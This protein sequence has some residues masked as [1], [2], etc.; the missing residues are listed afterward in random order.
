MQIATHFFN[1][2]G[3]INFCHDIELAPPS[4]YHENLTMKALDIHKRTVQAV[5]YFPYFPLVPTQ[6]PSGGSHGIWRLSIGEWL[7][8]Y[9]ADQ[10]GWGKRAMLSNIYSTQNVSGFDRRFSYIKRYT[11]YVALHAEHIRFS[12]TN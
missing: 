9:S 4:I 7:A 5:Y 3:D 8:E 6:M 12:E 2:P 10:I 1:K 11:V